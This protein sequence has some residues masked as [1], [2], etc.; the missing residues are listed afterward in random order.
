[1]KHEKRKYLIQFL[2]KL[3]LICSGILVALLMTA[4]LLGIH[5]NNTPSV[6]TGFYQRISAS[7]TKGSYVEICPPNREPF[8]T[9]HRYGYI[10]V[11]S[12]PNQMRFLLKKVAAMPGDT[13]SITEKGLTINGKYY[14]NSVPLSEDLYYHSF[15]HFFIKDYQLKENEVLLMGENPASYDARYFGLLPLSDVISVMKPV[16]IFY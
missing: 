3:S 14:P 8:L 1:M 13:I 10:K 5:Y 9:A 7:I 15:D 6:P 12:C 11:G 4:W 2:L 16:W